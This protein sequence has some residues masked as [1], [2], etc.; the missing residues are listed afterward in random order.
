M[1]PASKTDTAVRLLTVAIQYA[2]RASIVLRKADK[3][4][5]S[6]A[7]WHAAVSLTDLV[8]QLEDLTS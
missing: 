6:D 8:Q 1:S 7:A 3:R 5:G 4:A 2:M